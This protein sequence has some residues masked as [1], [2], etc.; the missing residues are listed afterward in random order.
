MSDETTTVATTDAST[1]APETPTAT[2]PQQPAS[3]SERTYTKSE[4]E[5]AMSQQMNKATQSLLKKLGIKADAKDID[6]QL[7][8]LK[9]YREEQMTAAEKAEA[10]RKTLE[11]ELATTRDE[12]DR[13]KREL[14]VT[15]AGIPEKDAAR[16]I[17]LAVSYMDEKTDFASAL[18]LAVKDYPPAKPTLPT[19]VAPTQIPSETSQTTKHRP[20]VG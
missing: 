15:R 11:G 16:Y 5:A 4:Y 8:A 9:T 6:A 20:L 3:T 17:R 14:A 2:E 19:A 18:A 1:A 13:H 7:T 10:A 12:L